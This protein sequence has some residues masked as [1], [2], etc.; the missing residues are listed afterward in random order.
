MNRAHAESFPC[1]LRIIEEE[2][3]LTILY[4]LAVLGSPSDAVSLS[5]MLRRR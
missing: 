2:N 5:I 4:E 1:W 3:D